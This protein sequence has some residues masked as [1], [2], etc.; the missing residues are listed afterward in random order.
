MTLPDDTHIAH[1]RLRVTDAEAVATFYE[2]LLHIDP[3]QEGETARF[4]ADGETVL[5]LVEDPDAPE[6]DP[7]EAGL[8]HTA[9]R[10]PT[11]GALGAALQRM[12]DAGIEL[13]GS[14]DHGV[15]EAV[16]C[17]DPE[18][19]GIELYRD[20]PR[21]EWDRGED[22]AIVMVTERLD[23]DA[24]RWD[25][26]EPDAAVV[27][28]VHLDVADLAE[29]RRFYEEVLGFP[30]QAT[31]RGAAFLGAGGYHH[32][33][34]L[35]EWHHRTEPRRDARRGMERFTVRVPSKEAL[36]GVAERAAEHGIAIDR[37][38]TAVSLT[39]P[40]GIRV[41]VAAE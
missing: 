22:G 8:Y 6:R 13:D 31:V 3:V 20:R 14:A 7:A 23:V 24:L 35:N 38:P 41:R 18:G 37:E 25:A 21:K 40:S 28:H 2:T 34:G 1:V 36:I 32:H 16:Y 5:E 27:G 15:S 11:R 9:F 19:N 39:D 29:S 12:D 17:T 33:V 10:F 30:L 4:V 26:G